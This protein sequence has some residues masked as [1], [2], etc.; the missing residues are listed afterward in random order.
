MQYLTVWIADLPAET[1]WYVPRT[2][3]SWRVL[4]WLL[5]ALHFAVPFAIL[6]SRRAKELRAWLAATA[7]L[8][9]AAHLADALWLVVPADRPRGL[10]L[11]LTDLLAP[12]GMGVLWWAVYAGVPRAPGVRG[13]LRRV[14]G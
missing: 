5:I 1:S 4:A 13:E 7:A 10:A 9:L 11:Q 3:T 2:L 8:L 14:H 12:A 6:L